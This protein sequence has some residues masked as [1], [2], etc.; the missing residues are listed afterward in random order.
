MPY[1]ICLVIDIKDPVGNK[2]FSDFYRL[3]LIPT[4]AF[5]CI[6]VYESKSNLIYRRLFSHLHFFGKILKSALK[7]TFSN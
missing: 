7:Y 2:S 6:T 1:V 5:H 3:S 4:Y